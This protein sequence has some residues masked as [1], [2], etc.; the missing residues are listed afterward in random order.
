[1][2]AVDIL[3]SAIQRAKLFGADLAIDGQRYSPVEAIQRATGGL[4]GDVAFEFV[5]TPKVIEQAM[6]SVRRGGRVVVVGIGDQEAKLL[7]AAIFARN[8]IEIVGSYGF[9]K[10]EIKKIVEM[11]SQG[12]LDLS[13]SVSHRITLDQANEGLRQ[14]E[15]KR[16]D[17]IRI[18]IVFP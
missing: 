16:G 3:D 18:V 12:M 8:E 2:I 6:A 13:R 5:G 11:V 14:L 15:A 4:G 1:V 10:M 7:P 9:E 17:P